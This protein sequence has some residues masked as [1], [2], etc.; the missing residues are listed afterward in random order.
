MGIWIFALKF[1]CQQKKT[2]QNVQKSSITTLDFGFK[3]VIF[4]AFFFAILH[5][6]AKIQR[7]T[8]LASLVKS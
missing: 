1:K 8:L 5:F 4:R 6:G 7:K 2:C 3:F